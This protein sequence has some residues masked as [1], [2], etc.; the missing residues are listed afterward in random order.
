MKQTSM[1]EKIQNVV[2]RHDGVDHVNVSRSGET[3]VGKLSALD[4]ASRFQVPF[5]GEFRSATCFAAYMMSGGVEEFRHESRSFRI[6]RG[7]TKAES[8]ANAHEFLILTIYAKFHQLRALYSNYGKSEDLT[9]L[10][11]V[12]YRR[13][14]SGVRQ[15][16]HWTLYAPSVRRLVQHLIATRNSADFKWSEI[17]PDIPVLNTVNDYLR[18]VAIESGLPEDE[19]KTIEQLEA[20]DKAERAARAERQRAEA[21]ERKLKE[22]KAAEG[23][24]E[25]DS[26]LREGAHLKTTAD[27][28][29]SRQKKP[30]EKQMLVETNPTAQMPEEASTGDTTSAPGPDVVTISA[31]NEAHGTDQNGSTTQEA[32]DSEASVS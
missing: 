7:A 17:F 14:E 18:F 13:L 25:D 10:R 8:E 15:F 1:Q 21:E 3:E 27:V 22:Q 5:L 12:A 24:D 4:W 9:G 19:V 2:M 28:V 20:A 31:N 16:D 29:G 23:S 6:P 26:Q 30:F 32:S 11:W